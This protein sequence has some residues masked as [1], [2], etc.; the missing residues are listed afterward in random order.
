M[1]TVDLAAAEVTVRTTVGAQQARVETLLADASTAPAELALG[2][3]RLAELY[4]A[5]GLEEAAL[6]G[7][8]NALLLDP[9][10][11]TWRCASGLA[12][13]AAG[14]AFRAVADFR[15]ALG[16]GGGSNLERGALQLHLGDTLLVLGR[17]AEAGRAFAAAAPVAG[18]A[19]AAESGLGRV[20]LREH[21]P[22]R[23]IEHFGRALEMQPRAGALRHRL[24]LGYRQRGDL[25]AAERHLALVTPGDVTFPDPLAEE[26]AAL[27]TSTGARARRGG[28]Q[29]V[30]DRP[31]AAVA[32][33]RT[34]VAADPANVAARRSLALALLEAGDGDAAVAELEA[35]RDLA[36]KD[37]WVLF[38]LGN[39]RQARGELGAAAAS[40]AAAL[41]LVPEFAS[42]RFNLANLLLRQQRWNEAS[43]QL[44]L[45]LRSDPTNTRARYQL[46]MAIA[47][48]GRVDD[49]MAALRELVVAEPRMLEA[50]QG[51]AELL[52][53]RGE[54]AAAADQYRGLL[55]ATERIADRGFALEQLGDLASRQG[56]LDGALAN[57]RQAAELAGPAASAQL[58]LKLAVAVDRSGEPAA[59]ASH[60][61]RAVELEPSLR[62]GWLGLAVARLAS[63]S[64]REAR[65]ALEDGLRAIPDDPG[66]GGALARVLATSSDARVRDGGRALAL[67]QALYQRAPSSGGAETLAMALAENG[68]FAEAERLIQEQ[69]A[70][71]TR[72]GRRADQAR[73]EAALR[74]YRSG[75]ATRTD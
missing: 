45:L 46:A 16:T 13:V 60:Y 53:G 40:F 63:G 31:D 3:G 41:A 65:A 24:A 74:L 1:P 39:A 56:D 17:T 33:Y 18:L 32:D 67:A 4:H 5:Y 48:S 52:L 9:S 10:S 7:Y 64:H 75:R 43:D 70:D 27:A 6:V 21:D 58:E 15:D 72:Q 22:S 19:A 54:V 30:N 62:Q 59:A 14:D 50:R 47:R 61:Q 12:R 51:L 25:A 44:R 34:A 8:Q 29:L 57:Y 20:A 36:P 71:A 26:I 66:L 69:I 73:L 55:A 42:A 11:F 35:A 49:G 28:R 68:R 2:F 37:I 38:D 23:A